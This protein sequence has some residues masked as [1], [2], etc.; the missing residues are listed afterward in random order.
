MSLKTPPKKAYD[1]PIVALYPERIV[2][3]D[4]VIIDIH[5]AIQHAVDTVIA[6]DHKKI[7][8]IGDPF[9]HRKATYFRDAAAAH[10]CCEAFIIESSHRFEQA[11]ED[12]VRQL[13]EKYPETSAIICGYDRIAY[14]AI[15]QLKAANLQIPQDISVVGVD[16]LG[17]SE[18]IEPALT[19]FGI[20]IQETC[21]IAWDL[22]YR[23][24]RN[25]G[26]RATQNIVVQTELVLRESLAPRTP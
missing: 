21:Q 4:S 26:F 18:Y 10:R 15:Q 6:Y 23:K 5:G 19:S 20:N 3:I 24:I 11:G 14:G 9:T 16:N 22:L 17:T 7:A 8:F 2:H 25:Q 1:T 12:G 13:L